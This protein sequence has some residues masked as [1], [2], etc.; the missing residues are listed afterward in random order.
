VPTDLERLLALL[1]RE[2][3]AAEV[4]LLSA[5][6]PASEEDA[7]EIT[8]RLPGGRGVAVRFE[9][10][11]AD[12][13]AK[14]R[15]LELLV[16]P[17]DVLVDDAVEEPPGPRERPVVTAALHDE[18]VA[19]C[20]R[21]VAVNALVIDANSP[22]VWGAAYPAGVVA[23]PPLAS[24]P[25]VAE[26]PAND[27]GLS[28][29][30]RAVVSRR[31]V[32]DVRGWPALGALRKGKHVRHVERGQESSVLAHSFASIYLLVLVFDAGFD[33]LR[34]ERATLEGLPRI[35]SLVLAL[36]PLDPDPFGGDR[37]VAVRKPRGR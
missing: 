34:A 10:P 28:A 11:P 29:S 7:R 20:G 37:A 14:L 35:E 2:F 9:E 3:G 31:A 30:S 23:E 24:S 18:L 25:R 5:E 12:R 8:C 4:R 26:A 27:E 21:A 36:P 33:E 19:L 17:F 32:H 15:R 6:E 13:D 16:A 1:R 22:V